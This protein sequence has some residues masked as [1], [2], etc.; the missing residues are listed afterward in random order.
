MIKASAKRKFLRWTINALSF[1]KGSVVSLLDWFADHVDELNRVIFVDEGALF[2]PV[3]IVVSTSGE[4][5]HGFGELTHGFKMKANSSGFETTN[6]SNAYD[7]IRRRSDEKIYIQINFKDKYRVKEHLA[8]LE[9]NPH[10]P[11]EH[12]SERRCSAAANKIIEAAI[13]TY[14]TKKIREDIDK[15]LDNKDKEE[16]ERLSAELVR[17]ELLL[18]TAGETSEKEPMNS[19]A[20]PTA[21]RLEDDI[22]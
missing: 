20:V 14:H 12:R 6:P 21:S 22:F 13:T 9:E 8:V 1:K 4:Q 7:W 16:F 5:T 18:P 15:A 2:C 17:L 10:I 11:E 3:G 19:V